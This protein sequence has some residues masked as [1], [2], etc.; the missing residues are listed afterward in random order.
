MNYTWITCPKQNTACEKCQESRS[1]LIIKVNHIFIIQV[2]F[3]HHPQKKKQH[4]PNPRPLNVCL[5]GGGNTCTKWAKASDG[6][7]RAFE[8]P[9]DMLWN[10][11]GS[12]SIMININTCFGEGKICVNTFRIVLMTILILSMFDVQYMKIDFFDRCTWCSQT[13][14][15]IWFFSGTFI[16]RILRFIQVTSA[17]SCGVLLQTG[18]MVTSRPLASYQH[19]NYLWQQVAMSG[20]ASP[21]YPF[22]PFFQKSW[23]WIIQPL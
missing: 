2:L 22:F 19:R 6:S 12:R 9:G 4:S 23:S 21:T 11:S 17:V 8:F 7:T 15:E 1:R 14:G 10:T 13:S 16:S 5:S 20:T 18:A 3:F